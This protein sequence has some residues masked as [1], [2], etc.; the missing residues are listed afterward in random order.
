ME[1]VSLKPSVAIASLVL[2]CGLV[3]CDALL[4]VH[5]F[6]QSAVIN[7]FSA[8]QTAMLPSQG[9][10]LPPITG[11]GLNGK[12]FGVLPAH[13][14]RFALLI[15]RQTCHFCEANWKNWDSLFTQDRLDLPVVMVTA[16]KT[17]EQPYLVKHP[18]LEHRFV[19]AGVDVSTLASLKLNLTPQTIYVVDGKISHDWPG[20][21][22]PDD[23][24]EISKTMR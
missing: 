23:I 12:E 13:T 24:N 16:D 5:S 9:A 2:I 18:M 19:V 21:L 14:P 3:A 11:V 17:I 22:S 20:V 8:K 10:V 4:M 7:S 1:N 6:H 15:F